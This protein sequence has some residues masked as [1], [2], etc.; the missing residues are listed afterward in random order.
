MTPEQAIA[1]ANSRLRLQSL[2]TAAPVGEGEQIMPA[3][4]TP[5]A[6]IGDYISS[7]IE[8]PATILSHGALAIPSAIANPK[9][10]TALSSKYGYSPQSPVSQDILSGLG[11]ATRYLPPYLGGNIVGSAMRSAS[12]LRN[13]AQI[14][15]EAVTQPIGQKI[16]QNLRNQ[17][18]KLDIDA[19]KNE[20]SSV[21]TQNE[22]NNFGKKLGIKNA[23]GADITDSQVLDILSPIP[24]MS[25]V[26]AA[27]V[28]PALTRIQTAQ[29]LRVPV[30]L[31]KGQATRDLGQQGFE[32][33][34]PKNY[35]ELGKRLIAKNIEQ[36]DKILQN[37]DAFINAT[38]KE[39]SGLIATGRV[40][41]KA[42]V[43]ASEKAKNEYRAS[44]KAA[45]KAGETRELIDVTPVKNYLDGLEAEE[46][47]AKVITSARVKLNKLAEDGKISINNLE[48]VRKMIGE[49]SGDTA[50]NMLYG[51]K[52]KNEIDAALKNQ[53]GDLYKNSRSLRAK[54]AR[55]FENL[56]YVDKLLQNKSGTTDRA[57]ALEDVFNHSILSGSRQDVQNIGLTLKK[58]GKDGQ[59][60]WK[61]LQGQTLQHIK[62]EVTKS[63][64]I[65]SA[66]DPVVS[67]AQFK[68]IVT[69]LDQ[70][71]KLDY[72]YGKKG[73]QEIRDLLETVINVNTKVKGAENTSNSSSAFIKGLDNIS[74]SPLGAIP[75]VKSISKNLSENAQEKMIKKQVEEAINFDP[76]KLAEQLRKE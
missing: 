52:I 70:D 21:L 37:F 58:A 65:N 45:E 49:V 14:A 60:A 74:K 68:R 64:N 26:G 18:A 11:D 56:G 32:T 2:S 69:T 63:V 20:Y 29:N 3:V 33:E 17:P 25:G 13:P 43:D 38:G 44:Y 39:T 54:Y 41:D 1:L 50:T 10:Q 7:L 23:N 57:V 46:A 76:Q 12:L 15:T 28:E 42:L 61:E 16:A 75:F 30:P 9:D 66:G 36:N 6:R 51:K 55:E 5:K 34:T 27:K 53:G 59:Q 72:I 35:P 47:N 73:A 40:V 8:V 31:T 48:E 19:L 71:G 4:E 24:T 67:P 22:L 62:D